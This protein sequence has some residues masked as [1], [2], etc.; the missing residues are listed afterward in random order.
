MEILQSR[1]I[2]TIIATTWQSFKAKHGSYTH[3][4]AN[5]LSH[6]HWRNARQFLCSQLLN[7][8]LCFND[9]KQKI[10]NPKFSSVLKQNKMHICN[11]LVYPNV[12]IFKCSFQWLISAGSKWGLNLVQKRTTHCVHW[13]DADRMDPGSCETFLGIRIRTLGGL[14]KGSGSVLWEA[15]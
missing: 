8:L 5:P 14:L 6:C 4:V 15:F 2:A 10:L 1:A 9:R 3:I 12:F 11:A 13:S 7:C